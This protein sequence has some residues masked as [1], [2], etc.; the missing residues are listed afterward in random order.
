MNKRALS[1]FL[2]AS[3]RITA[4]P[5]LLLIAIVLAAS[6]AAQGEEP[7]RPTVE[8]LRVGFGD[9]NSNTTLGDSLTKFKTGCWTPVEITLQGGTETVTGAV[10]LYVPDADGAMCRMVHP[11][12]VQLFPGKQTK[13]PMYAKFG[14][15]QADVRIRFVDGRG[16]ALINRTITSNNSMSDSL[17]VPWAM[18]PGERLIV[19][20]GPSLGV[21]QAAVLHQ[22]SGS[23]AITVAQIGDV[24][25]LPTEWYGYDGVDTVVITTSTPEIFTKLLDT[26]ARVAALE[27]WIELGGKL[28]L[29]VGS[30]GPTVL[31]PDSVLARFAPGSFLEPTTLKQTVALENYVGGGR[32]IPRPAGRDLALS[33]PRLKNIEGVTIVAEADLPL[34][35]R[36]PRHFGQ[37]TFVAVDLDRQ[38]FIEWEG[39]GLM[40]SRLLGLPDPSTTPDPN[41]VMN[42]RNRWMPD[43]ASQMQSGL[44][45]FTGV[46]RIPFALVAL[47]ILGYIVLIGP[48]DYFL[49]KRV[50][51]R[52]ELT[53]ITFPL[54]VI[55]VSG[56]AYVL[57][58]YTKGDDLR[59]NQVD[60]I[61][62]DTTTGLTRGTSWMN[63]FTPQSRTFNLSLIAKQPS[64]AD[65]AQADRLFAWSGAA[66]R[67]Y[68]GGGGGMFAGEYGFSPQLDSVIDAPIQVWSTKGFLGRSSYTSAPTVTADLTMDTS[69]VPIGKIQNGLTEPLA[70]CMLLSDRWAFLLGE[71]QPGQSVELKAGERRDLEQV[72]R[73]TNWGGA[74]SYLPNQNRYGVENAN[75][76]ATLQSMMFFKAALGTQQNSTN[77]M[78]LFLD[79]TDLLTLDRAILVGRGTAPAAQLATDGEPLEVPQ[80]QHWVVYRF[81][82]PVKPAAKAERE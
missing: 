24:A 77:G 23:E 19:A 47:L 3:S 42:A 64:G 4:Q 79:L 46:T 8:G 62:V 31:A 29:A 27:K 70:D 75:V 81:I 43:L 57:A 40:A 60:L 13:V 30:Q 10:E 66:N 34:V 6:G 12:P 37:I 63:L 61:D 58:R 73:T 45:T 2:R 36:T 38:P 21:E 76:L 51:K 35:V 68:G 54:W 49:V 50:L 48:G 32:K 41:N 67:A 9:G 55:L 82:F 1:T 39:R 22:S 72:L 59:L 33:V 56:G 26:G 16:K 20:I 52:M 15:Q 53:W 14:A 17:N 71:L 25:L 74:A 44:D 28:V 5:M 78:E 11:R 69:R 80:Q 7:R 65:A 18:Q